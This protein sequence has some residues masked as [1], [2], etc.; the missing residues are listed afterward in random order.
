MKRWLIASLIVATM[1][2]AAVACGGN[3]DGQAVSEIAAELDA[4]WDQLDR[5]QAIAEEALV[6]AAL[7]ALDSLRFHAMEERIVG[8]GRVDP[9]DPGFLQR[10]LQALASDGWPAAL[11][12][13]VEQF[14]AAVQAA[15]GPVLDNDA[16]AAARPVRVAHRH[17]HEFETAAA[18]YFAGR[19]VPPPPEIGSADVEPVEHGGEE[20]GAEEPEGE[21]HREGDAEDEQSDEDSEGHHD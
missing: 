5:T 20:H 15:V 3:D 16:E 2:L 10:A 21:D 11:R 12:P 7:P 9:S 14:H 13:N 18:A 1:A 19:D 8:E 4:M 6:R 17:A